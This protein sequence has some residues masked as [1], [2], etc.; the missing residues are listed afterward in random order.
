MTR[1]ALPLLADKKAKNVLQRICQE[2][3]VSLDL[4][5]SLIEIQRDNL[6]RGRQVGISQEFSAAIS[7]FI[8][9]HQAGVRDVS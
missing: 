7:D 8:E 4:L 3:N 5:R 2:H 6:G 9:E 1:R